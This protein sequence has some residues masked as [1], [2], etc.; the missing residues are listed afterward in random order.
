MFPAAKEMLLF[1]TTFEKDIKFQGRIYGEGAGAAHPL[2]PTPWDD[3]RLSNTT[4]IP[5]KKKKK[6]CGLLVLK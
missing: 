2:L 6:L 4:G 1:A 3:L 5:Q